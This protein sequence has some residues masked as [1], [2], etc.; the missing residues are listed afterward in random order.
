MC[1]GASI[2]SF[3]LYGEPHRSAVEGFVHVESLDDRSRPSEWTIRPH[4]HAELCQIFFAASGGGTMRAED[5]SIRFEAPCLLL[6]PATMVHAFAWHAESSGSVITL[7][8]SYLAEL[9]RR[10]ADTTELFRMQCVVPLDAADARPMEQ[11]IGDLIREL[12]WA[13]P[14]HRAA[15]DSILLSILVMALRRVRDSEPNGHGANHGHYSGIV[16]RLRERVEQRFR[17]REPVTSYAVALGV[18]VTALR[19][20]CARVAGVPPARILDQRSL[21]EARR[22]LLYST[23]SVTEIGY[24]IGFS[25]P[26]YFSRFFTRHIGQSPRKYRA[27]RGMAPETEQ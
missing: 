13:A 2:P 26:A 15:V 25:D 6:V 17:L 19:L 20:A 3:Y 22:A 24:A 14:G 21:L 1:S 5:R 4:A 8:S 11:R 12:G 7:A 9:T 10:D 27:L 16:A 18:S 23:L